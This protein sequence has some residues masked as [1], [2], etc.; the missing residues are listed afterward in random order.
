MSR[1]QRQAIN[2]GRVA[3]M[4]RAFNVGIRADTTLGSHPS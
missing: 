3:K 2:V 1:I 4:T